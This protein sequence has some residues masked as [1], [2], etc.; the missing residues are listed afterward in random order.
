MKLEITLEHCVQSIVLGNTEKKAI[1]KYLED[2]YAMKPSSSIALA[3]YP[4]EKNQ[5]SKTLVGATKKVYPYFYGANNID[6]V[7]SELK[8]EI[9]DSVH[10]AIAKPKINIEVIL[11]VIGEID[12]VRRYGDALLGDENTTSDIK[13]MLEIKEENDLKKILLDA[14]MS[15]LFIRP[16]NQLRD[17]KAT[18]A[19]SDVI[20][21]QKNSDD[22]FHIDGFAYP[23]VAH[24][25]GINFAIRGSAFEQKME[26]C[27]CI[28]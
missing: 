9:G 26:I 19:L 18:S 3:S 11:T 13:K 5:I 8:P 16:A 2:A 15:E 22:E 4:I 27:E 17:Y 7:L 6:T 21:S 20:L 12:H 10:L 1:G 24:R 14:F 28:T 25:G 23:S